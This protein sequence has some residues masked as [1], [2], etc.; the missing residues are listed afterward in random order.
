MSKFVSG[1]GRALSLLSFAFGKGAR[2]LPTIIISQNEE[3]LVLPVTPVKYEVGN[4]QGNKTVDI[5]Q[6]GEVLLFGNPKLKTLSFEGFFP[7]KDYPFIVGDK[8]KPIEIINL[9]EKW[10][11]S[12]KPVRVIIS[13]GPINLMMGIESFPYKKQENTGDMYYTLTFKEHKDLNTPATGDDKPVDETTGLKDRPSVAQ[14]PKTAT[15]FSK[16]SDVLDAAKKAYGNYR[17]YERIIQSNDLKNLA[18]NNLSQ[19][20]K[21]K[22]K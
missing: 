4:E 22:V 21:L 19:L 8:R 5:T 13:D 11:T 12:K 17:H 14:K 9:I 1:I 3:K 16:G 20:R 7:A 10:K 6:I 2:E 18:I 15:L